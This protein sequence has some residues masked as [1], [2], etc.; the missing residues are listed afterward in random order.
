[1]A[2]WAALRPHDIVAVILGGGAGTRLFPLTKD[3]AKPAVPLAGQ[4]PAGRHPHQQLPQLRAAPDLRSHPVQQQLAAPAHPGE[5]PVRQ[6]LARV[7]RDPR[8]AAAHR[9]RELV[10]GHRRRGPPEPG[11]PRRLPAPAGADPLGRPALPDELPRSSSSS[12]VATGA[13]VTVATT[14]VQPEA[15]RAFGIME[16]APR[17]PRHPVRR[18]AVRPRGSRPRSGWTGAR[19]RSS[20]SRWIRTS[21]RPPWASTSSTAPCSPRRSPAPRRTSASTSSPGSSG[22]AGSTPSS[23]RGTGRTSGPSAPS[24][25]PTSTSA[26]RCPSST[27]TTPPRRSSPTRAICP[28]PRSSRAGSSGRS[29]PT[30]ASSTTR[31]IEHSLIGVRSRIEA[32]AT[33]RDSLIMGA[34]YYETPDRAAAGGR[35]ADRHRPGGHDRAHHRGQERPDRRR[36]AHLARG[37]AAELR[38][39][40][41]LRARR[42]RGHSQGRGDPE[43]H[44]R[45]DAIP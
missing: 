18:E 27:S 11:S 26:R 4:V 34:D 40:Q 21:C 33:I 20:R 38:R 6:L 12:H 42:H 29:S 10:P 25:R 44:A 43:R 39:A 45:S 31:V 23:T 30:A 16:T 8:G 9:A 15:A 37:K 41:L 22:P 35:A 14:P 32:G 3:R 5:L 13:E 17:R 24:T 19:S 7:R 1:M 36:R 2:T 28:A